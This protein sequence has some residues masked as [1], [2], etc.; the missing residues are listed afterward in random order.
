MLYYAA[1]FLSLG[2]IAGGG[3][4]AWSRHTSD[5]GGLDFAVE[6]G[7]LGDHPQGGGTY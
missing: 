1:I 4:C 5:S 2:V 7:C 6:W 3:E